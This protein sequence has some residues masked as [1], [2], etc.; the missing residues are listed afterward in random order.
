LGKYPA[1]QNKKTKK[2]QQTRKQVG[3]RE[4]QRRC[5][6]QEESSCK[7]VPNMQFSIPK[8]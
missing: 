7:H 6:M 3:E 1:S 5:L 8:L 4:G 2:L